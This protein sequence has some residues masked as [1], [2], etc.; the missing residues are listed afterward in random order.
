MLIDAIRRR[1]ADPRLWVSV[2][3]SLAVGALV[4]VPGV[5]LHLETAERA[6]IAGTKRIQIF[7][8]WIT[9]LAGVQAEDDY[10][11]GRFPLRIFQA[12]AAILTLFICIGWWRMRKSLPRAVSACAAL[13]VIPFILMVAAEPIS[14]VSTFRLLGPPRYL[15][16]ILPAAAML[17]ATIAFNNL[18]K[19]GATLLFNSCLSVFL[20]AGSY[21]FLTT[22]T[23]PL[24]DRVRQM[25]KRYSPSDAVIVVPE[26]IADGVELYGRGVHVNRAI[27]RKLQ[28]RAKITADLKPLQ[29][30]SAVWLVWYRGQ[31][32][33]VLS[34][35]QELF[36]AYQSNNKKKAVGSLRIFHF[37]P[38]TTAPATISPDHIDE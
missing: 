3:V 21:F 10:I 38:T 15:I 36:G 7:A 1:R 8:H 31:G 29:T 4:F 11:A 6:G 2:V 37:D 18:R 17:V 26:E 20:L 33:P 23:E 34:I 5:V 25:A 12:I 35:S 14:E 16:S 30:R 9:M 19:P 32:S 28:D 27:N 22:R 13:V 24:R